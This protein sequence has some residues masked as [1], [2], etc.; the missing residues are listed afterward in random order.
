MSNQPSTP[1]SD[2][3]KTG[4]ERKCI[5]CGTKRAKGSLLRLVL[6]EKGQVVVDGRHSAPGRGAYLCGPG[7]LKAAA[8]R[9]ALQRAFRGKVQTLELTSLEASLHQAR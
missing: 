9:K 3:R 8:V 6:D 7:C 1:Q 5:G 2:K 4:A